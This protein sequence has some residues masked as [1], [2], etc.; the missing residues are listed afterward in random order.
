MTPEIYAQVASVS[1]DARRRSGQ[2]ERRAGARASRAAGHD[3]RDAQPD[4][5]TAIAGP[6]HR[7]RRPESLQSP[8]RGGRPLPGQ[9]ASTAAVNALAG[10]TERERRQVELTI[11]ARVGPQAPP[12]SAHRR[13]RAMPGPER[14]PTSRPS[15]GDARMV[16]QPRADGGA[17]RAQR[18]MIAISTNEL[19]GRPSGPSC[20]ATARG[21]CRS[22]RRAKTMDG[23]RSPSALAELA[24]ALGGVGASARRMARSRLADAA[25][26]RGAPARAPAASSDDELQRLL[27]RDA[28]RYFVQRARPADRRRV[29]GHATSCARAPVPVVAAAASARLIA[30]IRGAA[31]QT[32]WTRRERSRRPRARGQAR[33]SRSGPS[34]ARSRGRT[35][36]SRTTIGRTCCRSTEGRLVGRASLP[37][38]RSRRAR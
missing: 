13:R 30:A 33:R 1:H 8:G 12:T 27:A 15:N 18:V 11:T 7:E 17:R 28:S 14:R 34:F 36:S 9:L 32:G 38:R 31:Q 4:P 2:P 22:S 10:R 37:R 29:A 35:R 3:R 23:R 20:P 26:H 5:A 24:R 19:R 21:A 6:A 25:A 16:S